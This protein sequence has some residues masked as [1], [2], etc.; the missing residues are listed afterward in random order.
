MRV[1][2]GDGAADDF[3]INAAGDLLGEQCSLRK[4]GAR[5]E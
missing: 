3:A 5:L 1:D 4:H 2:D